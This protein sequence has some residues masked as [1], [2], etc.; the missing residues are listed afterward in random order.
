[1]LFKSSPPKASKNSKSRSKMKKLENYEIKLENNA[2]E[3]G[4]SN[5]IKLSSSDTSNNVV[6]NAELDKY[7]QDKNTSPEVNLRSSKTPEA[8]VS[9]K[10]GDISNPK[11]D[12][13]TNKNY[14]S[15]NSDAPILFLDVNFGVSEVTRIIMYK[16]DSPRE[17]AQAFCKEHGLSQ[18]KQ[19][20]LVK[21]IKHHLKTA[22]D[23]ID[24]EPE[25]NYKT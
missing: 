7:L 6:P 9:P 11:L 15:N 12:N 1:M 13:Y 17:L 24:E 23:K 14:A 5:E 22:L 16:D 2:T 21:I 25:E 19:E 4:A 20:K 3:S 10:S 8:N 18:N